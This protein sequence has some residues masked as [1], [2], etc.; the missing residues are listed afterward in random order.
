MKVFPI[1]EHLH[2]R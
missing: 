1:E 2:I